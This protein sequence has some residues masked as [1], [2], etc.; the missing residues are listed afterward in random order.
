MDTPVSPRARASPFRV[1]VVVAFGVS[2]LVALPLVM[3]SGG[4]VGWRPPAWLHVFVALGPAAGAVAAYAAAGGRP[5]V[6]ALLLRLRPGSVATPAW[7][8][9]ALSPLAAGALAVTVASAVAPADWSRLTAT[10]AYTVGPWPVALLATGVAFG[11][12]EELGWRGFA[13]P[14][15]QSSHTAA[16]A[17]WRLFLLWALWHLPMFFYHFEFGLMTFGWLT[18]L[19]FGTVWQTYL[20]NGTGGSVLAVALWHTTYNVVSLGGEVVAPAAVP[21]IGGAVVLAALVVGRR[22][23]GPDLAPHPRV[24]LRVLLAPTNSGLCL[25]ARQE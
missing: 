8:A 19:Y 14:W 13:L 24:T 20:F 10:D 22:Y 1:F 4:L 18:A 9:A 7:W 5:A 3:A 25:A 17:T 2:W 23:G 12:G 21:V 11:F 6:A 16:G 15:W